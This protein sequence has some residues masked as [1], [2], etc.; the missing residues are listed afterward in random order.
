MTILLLAAALA[1]GYGLGRWRPARRASSW[2]HWL[3][4]EQPPVT[5][6]D[7][8]WWAAQP[9]YACEI[10]VLLATQPRRTMHAWRHR[11]DPPPPRGPALRVRDIREDHP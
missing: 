10:G 3:T 2:A 1:A 6:S 9:V 8:R 11:N 7:W 5:R 4:Y